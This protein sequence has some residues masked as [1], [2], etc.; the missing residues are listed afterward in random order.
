[1]IAGHD[2]WTS[3]RLAVIQMTDPEEIRPSSESRR[4]SNGPF[5]HFF[6]KVDPDVWRPVSAEPSYSVPCFLP[7]AGPERMRRL[8]QPDVPFSPFHRRTEPEHIEEV[9]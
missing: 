9:A 1:L 3:D 2:E 4:R 8:G 7:W 5:G 6:P